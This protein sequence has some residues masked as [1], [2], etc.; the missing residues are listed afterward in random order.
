MSVAFVTFVIVQLLALAHLHIRY[1]VAH[2]YV[3][4]IMDEVLL[5]RITA[6][7]HLQRSRPPGVGLQQLSLRASDTT[8]GSKSITSKTLLFVVMLVWRKCDGLRLCM[9]QAETNVHVFFASQDH[10]QTQSVPRP[11]YP[12]RSYR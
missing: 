5:H 9:E 2:F 4:L 7:Q 11:Q 1:L 12:T 10:P 3:E 6:I 8:Q